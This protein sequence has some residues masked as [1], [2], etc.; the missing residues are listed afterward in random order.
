MTSGEVVGG[1]LLSG[2]EL[3]GMEQLSISAGPDLIND[4]R[5]KVKEDSSGNVLA[6]TSL[7]EKCVEGVI[8]ATDGLVRWHLAIRLDT[9]LKTKQLP[10]GVT[11]LDAPLSYVNGDHF[12]HIYD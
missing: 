12:S 9:M 4:G 7:G 5:L 3:L 1:I 6:S 2:D 11:D 10:A 8:T